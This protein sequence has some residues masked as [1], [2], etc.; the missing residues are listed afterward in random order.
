MAQSSFPFE[1]VDTSETQ[2]SQMFRN[3]ASG[4]NGTPAGTELKVTAGTGLVVAVAAGQA[5]VRGHYYISTA[6]ENL[7]LTA[8][9]PTNPRIDSIVLTLDPSANSIVL[10]VVAG[11]PA[12]SPVAPTLTQT[13]AG[14]YQYQLATVA[15]AAGAGSVGTITDT[16]NFFGSRFGIWSTAGRPSAPFTGQAGYNS[17]LGYPEYWTGSAWSSFSAAPTSIASGIVTT[18]VSDKSTNYTIVAG[19][20]NTFI[21]ST[22]GTAVTMTIANV[23]AVGESVTFVQ[24][25]AGQITFAAGSGVTLTSY[26]NYLKAAGQHATV[27]VVCVASGLYSLAGNLVA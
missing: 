18:V 10:A 9:N 16:R 17:T 15:V 6:S 20:K 25:G 27:S 11:T 24:Y 12:S 7:T 2:F 22:S 1:N 5:M 8:A 19:D 14:V 3:F 13:D 21:R 4:V 26:N 23:L